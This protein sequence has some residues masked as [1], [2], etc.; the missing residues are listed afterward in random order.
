MSA[1]MILSAVLL[2]AQP[3]LAA[4]PKLDDYA[5][6]ITVDAAPGQPLVEVALPDVVYDTVTRA[7]LGDVRVFNADGMPVPHALC[8]APE[9]VAP[10]VTEQSLPVFE[11]RE[12]LQKR[13]GAAR[14]DVQTSAGTQVHVQEGSAEAAAAG[15][16]HIIDARQWSQPLRAIQFD[17]TSP[18]G[19]SEAR[20][21]IETSDDLDRWEVVVPASTLL[22]ATRGT[23]QLKRG[24][25][26]LLPRHYEYLRVERAD[27]GAPL[28]INGVIG[29]L[30]TEQPDV[31][32]LWFMPDA[33]P[34][35][36]TDT[37][38]FDAGRLAPVRFARLR[39]PQDNSSVRVAVDSRQDT[40]S[41][42]RERWAGESYVVVTEAQR[43]ESPPAR[44]DATADRYWRVRIMQ[45]AQA[46]RPTGLELGYF[47]ARLRFLSQGP[48]PYTIA[49]GSQRAPIV[50]T[51]A[52]D[53]L[54]ADVSAKDRAQMIVEGYAGAVRE[55]GGDAAFQPLPKKTP[56]RL[57]VLWSVLIMG[58]ALLVTM[59]LSL[60]KRLKQPPG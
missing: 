18:D 3:A 5:R 45:E 14:I 33:T 32:P 55:L 20:V 17:W 48:A 16:T 15:R 44:F 54:L 11:L 40:K 24:R 26:E 21:R 22:M 27:G 43:R 1:R 12:A 39:M 2:L 23:E 52:C 29:E 10:V 53:A 31:E 6:G 58:V 50:A 4:A 7:D 57:I 37:M 19:A 41:A 38:L 8:A 60:L 56:L 30:L 9:A 13:A 46:Q 59:A 36:T 25:I 49:F 35:E 47:A 28:L 34:A 42:W 51:T